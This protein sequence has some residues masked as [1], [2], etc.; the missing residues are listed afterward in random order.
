MRS[1]GILVAL[2]CASCA[3]DD[4]PEPPPMA[5]R[6]ATGRTVAAEV[7]WPALGAIDR[8]VLAQLSE[9]SRVAVAQSRVPVLLVDDPGL[10]GQ[11]IVMAK[12]AFT[13]ISAR[14]DGVT[15]SLHIHRLAHRH[16]DIP[17]AEGDR[18][19]RGHRGFV[20][21]NEA[22]WSASWHENGVAYDLDVECGTLPDP[23]CESDGY[24]L[25][26]ADSLRYVGGKQHAA[27]VLR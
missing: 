25:S 10:A 2:L 21:Q 13:A 26:L 6:T 5:G 7:A 24:L 23:R 3:Q 9:A 15:M 16:P 19:I 18:T 20:T 17:S 8:S 27:E 11:A 12:P 1:A 4:K 22:I 14:H